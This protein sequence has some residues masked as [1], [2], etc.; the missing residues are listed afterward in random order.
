MS[1]QH[2]RNAKE[3]PEAGWGRRQRCGAEGAPGGAGCRWRRQGAPRG[4]AGPRRRLAGSRG[5]PGIGR[6]NI[7]VTQHTPASGGPAAPVKL[8]ADA[9]ATVET[10]HYKQLPRTA[11]FR[12]RPTALLD[13]YFVTLT[14]NVWSAHT[15]SILRATAVNTQELARPLITFYF[16]CS[17]T[18]K[19]QT[20]AP[21]KKPNQKNTPQK[22][23]SGGLVSAALLANPILISRYSA[24]DWHPASPF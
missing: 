1:V 5:C 8:R 2:R 12:S 15:S 18:K 11:R 4:R 21:T 19:L 3:S 6:S 13:L 10:G 22:T 24:P 23:A 17:S 9:I 7:P 20:L 16:T 14:R